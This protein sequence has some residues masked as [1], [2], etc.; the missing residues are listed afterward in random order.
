MKPRQMLSS[1]LRV[2]YLLAFEEKSKNICF[3]DEALQLAESTGSTALETAATHNRTKACQCALCKCISEFCNIINA[4]CVERFAAGGLDSPREH[5]QQRHVALFEQLQ[6]HGGLSSLHW[7]CTH[8][9]AP[10]TNNTQYITMIHKSSEHGRTA[11]LHHLRHTP[12]SWSIK[13]CRSRMLGCLQGRI[14]CK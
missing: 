1:E 4:W 9:T 6:Q 7:F 14:I 11:L 3:H 10:H 5:L 8:R 2:Q 12:S 13:Q